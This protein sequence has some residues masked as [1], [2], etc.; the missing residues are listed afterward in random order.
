MAIFQLESFQEYSEYQCYQRTKESPEGYFHLPS[1]LVPKMED[2]FFDFM[3]RSRHH[4]ATPSVIHL[5][6]EKKKQNKRPQGK[7]LPRSY[8]NLQL[9]YALVSSSCELMAMVGSRY[10]PHACLSWRSATAK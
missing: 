1:N 9:E 5:Q 7:H 6:T 3:M 8:C 4:D 2:R 10:F